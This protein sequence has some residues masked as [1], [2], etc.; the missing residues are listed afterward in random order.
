MTFFKMHRNLVNYLPVSL[1]FLSGTVLNLFTNKKERKPTN[2]N[3]IYRP[4]VAGGR[5]VEIS[6]GFRLSLVSVVLNSDVRPGVKSSSRYSNGTSLPS[7]SGVSIL[8]LP[9]T[10]RTYCLLLPKMPSCQQNMK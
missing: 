9:H 1:I 2:K 5:W 3:H 8:R 10:R 6:N 7:K 4:T